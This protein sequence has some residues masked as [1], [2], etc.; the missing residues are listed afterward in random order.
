VVA[1]EQQPTPPPVPDREG[2]HPAELGDHAFAVLFVEMDQ[3]L[4]IG[5][6]AEPVPLGHQRR[7]ELL[8]IVDLAVEDQQDAAVLVAHRLMPA[9][10]VHDAEAAHP[11]AHVA[12]HE[13]AP[14]VR[15]AVRDGV[16]HPP[17][18]GLG[19][20]TVAQATD[21]AAH[22]TPPFGPRPPACSPG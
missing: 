13:A 14:V 18:L 12:F 17:D 22:L 5:A 20:R 4:G 15:P 19:D 11:Q 1:R 6:G 10:D 7:A 3:R 21:D 16:A 2:E 8:V 9:G